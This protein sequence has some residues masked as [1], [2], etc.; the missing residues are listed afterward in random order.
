MIRTGNF[1]SHNLISML[2]QHAVADKLRN[3][4]TPSNDIPVNRSSFHDPLK[5]E[6]QT[7]SLAAGASAS[8]SGSNPLTQATSSCRPRRSPAPTPP[9]SSA[10]TCDQLSAL[11][12]WL[13]FLAISWAVPTMR[14]FEHP[15]CAAQPTCIDGGCAAVTCRPKHNLGLLLWHSCHRL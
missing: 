4:K 2:R 3:P 5:P 1:T 15:A 7:P 13:A 6:T 10:T 12:F 8:R 14:L 11:P 9:S